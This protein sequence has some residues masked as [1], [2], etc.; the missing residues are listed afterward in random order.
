MKHVCLFT[1]TILV[2]DRLFL[3]V[4]LDSYSL[5]D[6]IMSLKIPFV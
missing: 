1:S 2:P 4:P 5:P 3:W 6:E